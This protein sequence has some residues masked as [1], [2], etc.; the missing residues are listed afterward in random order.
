MDDKIDKFQRTFEL[1]EVAKPLVDYLYK[2]GC[3]HDYVIVSQVHT[4][5][6]SGE[7]VVHNA[8]RD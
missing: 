5:H 3:P 4:E 1:L 6:V 2:Y 7:V 8:I